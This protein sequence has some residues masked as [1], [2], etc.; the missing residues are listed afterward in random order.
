[1][2]IKSCE[3]Q[4]VRFKIKLHNS[5]KM[6]VNICR[7]KCISFIG[8][9]VHMSVKKYV[10]RRYKYLQLKA[11]TKGLRCVSMPVAAE[12]HTNELRIKVIKSSMQ[13]FDPQYCNLKIVLQ[14][15]INF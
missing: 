14:F 7:L 1:M 5:V 15:C 4:N 10:A 11:D 12:R 6:S 8:E 3:F 2:L 13:R 9:N